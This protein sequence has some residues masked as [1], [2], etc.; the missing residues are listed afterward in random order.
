MRTPYMHVCVSLCVY[1]CVYNV[2]YV[3][4]GDFH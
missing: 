4:S 2:V 3:M 1:L